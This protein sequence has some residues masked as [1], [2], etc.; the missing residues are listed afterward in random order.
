MELERSDTHLLC[1]AAN[2]IPDTLN[3]SGRRGGSNLRTEDPLRNL[4]PSISQSLPTARCENVKK[5]GSEA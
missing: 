1:T 2:A 3:V 5:F 4:G